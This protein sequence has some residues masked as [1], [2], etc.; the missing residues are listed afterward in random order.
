MNWLLD[1]MIAVSLLF[2]AVL[3]VRRPMAELFGARWAYALWLLPVVRAALPPIP[4]FDSPFSSTLSPPVFIPPA[5]GVSAPLQ[6]A[7]AGSEQWLG[8]IVA[9]WALGACMFLAWQLLSYRS[10]VGRLKDSRVGAISLFDNLVVVESEAV[11]GPLA[12]GLF[13]RRIVVPLDFSTRYSR[14]E[15]RLALEHEATHHRRGDIWWNVAALLV[16]AINWFNPLAYLA[17]RAFR[18]DQELSCDAA[19]TSRAS[20]S[21]RHDYALALV[22]SASRPGLIA[23]C[24]LNHA[25]QLKRRLKMMKQHRAS[26]GRTAGGLAAVALALLSGL[27]VSAPTAA[28]EEMPTHRL[29]ISRADGQAAGHMA[30]DIK[31]LTERC[32]PEVAKLRQ[33]AKEVSSGKKPIRVIFCGKNGMVGDPELSAGLAEALAR[34]RRAGEGSAGAERP[35]RDVAVAVRTFR[36]ER[37]ER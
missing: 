10:L 5:G 26:K 11:Q 1:T 3:L 17:F 35:H 28:R 37:Q 36:Q 18:T 19:V 14:M 29:F 21:E 4:A 34:A 24:P 6:A 27:F 31:A 20:S 8:V 2:A 25:G 30:V 9:V 13:D 12:M 15:Q 22:K 32:G 7:A 16:L 33:E 23:A